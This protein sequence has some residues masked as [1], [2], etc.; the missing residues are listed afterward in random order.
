M[1]HVDIY[2][3]GACS[4]NPGPG[5]WAAVL[6]F[7][8]LRKELSGAEPDTTNNR[9]EITAAIRALEILKE[10]CEITLTTDS[11]YL[12]QGI[13]KWM[14]A[15]KKNGWKTSNKQPVKNQDLWMRLDR[16]TRK[17]EITWEWV[18]GHADHPENERCDKLAREA[19]RRL[20]SKKKK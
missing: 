18:K 11:Q 14:F 1:K 2:T 3:D 15:W 4:G 19:I 12:R 8:P 7:G 9:M 6:V 16:L 10:Q 20:K 13:T 5:G 17:H